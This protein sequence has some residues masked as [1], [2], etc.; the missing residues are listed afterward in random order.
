[1]NKAGYAGAVDNSGQI[2]DLSKDTFWTNNVF[3]FG[4]A[5]NNVFGTIT[6]VTDDTFLGNSVNDALGQGG[7]IEKMKAPSPPWPTTPSQA[8]A[9]PSAVGSTMRKGAS[10][11]GSRG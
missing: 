2:G 8:T 11:A 7:A 3:G 5:L 9:R 6:S 4:G 10:S 1:M